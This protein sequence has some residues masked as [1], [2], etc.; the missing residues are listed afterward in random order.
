M[1]YTPDI[2]YIP[3]TRCK[4]SVL[5]SLLILFVVFLILGGITYFVYYT[6]QQKKEKFGGYY[7]TYARYDPNEDCAGRVLSRPTTQSC[8]MN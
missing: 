1:E 7:N 3:E 6:L 2:P 5:E 8:W 4:E